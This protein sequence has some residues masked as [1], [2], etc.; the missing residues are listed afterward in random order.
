M[1]AATHF[2]Q[3]FGFQPPMLVDPIDNPFD[4]AFAPW[5]LRFYI[6]HRG[7]IA[8]KAQPR[9]CSYSLSE[10]RERLLHL[11]EVEGAGEG[12]PSLP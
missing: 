10:L 5:P 3:Q 9:E 12:A 4:A 1:A 11:L 2:V 6:L 8:Y 7:C